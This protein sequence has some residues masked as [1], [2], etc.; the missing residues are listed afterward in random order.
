MSSDLSESKSSSEHSNI[1]AF[2]DLVK[3]LSD[4]IPNY[5][6][7]YDQKLYINNIT[8][9][10]FTSFFNTDNLNTR[11]T[12]ITSSEEDILKKILDQKKEDPSIKIHLTLSLLNVP[13]DMV[14]SPYDYIDPEKLKTINFPSSKDQ[15]I[16]KTIK[17][18]EN[19]HDSL[20]KTIHNISHILNNNENG[21]FNENHIKLLQNSYTNTYSSIKNIEEYYEYHETFKLPELKFSEQLTCFSNFQW[22]VDSRYYERKES[23]YGS[24]LIIK[25]FF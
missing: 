4:E 12:G 15:E 13:E 5:I 7:I 10:P 11:H 24:C 21:F 17:E 20:L 18:Y 6:N 19:I 1:P 8:S 2:E 9:D 14:L 23:D 3:I 22:Y 25:T 16:I